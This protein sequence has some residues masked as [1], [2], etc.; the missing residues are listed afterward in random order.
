MTSKVVN[1]APCSITRVGKVNGLDSLIPS[2]A[3][4]FVK[5]L[6]HGRSSPYGLWSIKNDSEIFV[7]AFTFFIP[8]W[9]VAAST[10][11]WDGFFS[12][13]KQSSAKLMLCF[14]KL[15]WVWRW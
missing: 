4:L 2:P 13:R 7:E 15:S 11:T 10:S 5:F 3:S 14:I 9:G 8:A 1:N 12:L 6:Q